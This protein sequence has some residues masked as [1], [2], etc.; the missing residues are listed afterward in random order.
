MNICLIEYN[1][2]CTIASIL[3][4]TLVRDDRLDFYEEEW[5]ILRT[6]LFYAHI[7]SKVPDMVIVTV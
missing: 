4:P 1:I 7:A 3:S 2:L 6:K 5:N